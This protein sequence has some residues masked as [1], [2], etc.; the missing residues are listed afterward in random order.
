M[1][2][3]P[4]FRTALWLSCVCAALAGCAAGGDRLDRMEASVD[5]LRS[6]EI[7]MALLEDKV[8]A[9]TGELA[10]LKA[11]ANAPE[12]RTTP[13]PKGSRSA[14]ATGKAPAVPPLETKPA[15]VSRKGASPVADSSYRAALAAFEAGRMETARALFAD[16]LKNA[17]SSPLAPNAGYWLGECYYNLKQFDTAIITFKDVVAKYPA[18]PKAAAC[19]LKAGFAYARLGD[20]ANAKFYLETLVHDF[21]DSEP[22]KLARQRLAS[23]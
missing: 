21:P 22:A 9:L 18:H 13:V 4:F 12:S 15:A 14:A 16:F 17:P 8:N 6:Q 5:A 23:L 7:R 10:A 3:R 2:V 19:M 1:S 11:E 20:T